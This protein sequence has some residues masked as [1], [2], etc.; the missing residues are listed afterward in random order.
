M[1][2]ILNFELKGGKIFIFYNKDF[3][4]LACFFRKCGYFSMD[5]FDK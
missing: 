5:M 4:I 2:Q 1:S 3:E